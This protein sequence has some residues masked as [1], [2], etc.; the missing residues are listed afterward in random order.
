VRAGTS[1]VLTAGGAPFLANYNG[2]PIGVAGNDVGFSVYYKQ[3]DFGLVEQV[4]PRAFLAVQGS[5]TASLS[6]SM[7]V[8]IGSTMSAPLNGIIDYC[9]LQSDAP[10]TY[11]CSSGQPAAHQRCQS[12]NHRLILTR[13]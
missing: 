5:A 12:A 13:R 10:W 9:A 2:F 4:A 11:D 1:L 7:G 8:S 6:G 3:E